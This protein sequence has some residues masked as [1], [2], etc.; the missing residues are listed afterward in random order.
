[1]FP[2]ENRARPPGTGGGGWARDDTATPRRR[3]PRRRWCPVNPGPA[4]LRPPPPVDDSAG[5]AA[6]VRRG[7]MGGVPRR[8]PR[9]S[10]GPDRRNPAPAG[11]D[12]RPGQPPVTAWITC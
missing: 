5:T 10:S 8:R 2:P 1:M 9:C 4:R 12:L 7:V 6:G 11:R 3:G